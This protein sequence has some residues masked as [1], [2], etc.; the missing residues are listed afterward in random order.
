MA[1]RN[2]NAV[3]AGTGWLYAAEPDG[4]TPEP[5][6]AAA[7]TDPSA[8]PGGTWAGVGYTD[9]GVRLEWDMT[10]EDIRVAEEASP[11]RTLWTEVTYRLALVA[12]QFETAL[13]RLALNG[14]VA[15]SVVGPPE[16]ETFAPPNV[17]ED[18][19]TSLLF[20]F[21]NEYGAGSDLYMAL[22]KNT[23]SASVPFTRAPQKSTIALEFTGQVPAEGPVWSLRQRIDAT[24]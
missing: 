16:E 23:A 19:P 20:R 22:A 9:D 12:A 21:R 14:G 5:A 13:L 24:S 7:P 8:A 4:L 2:P 17:G 11:L 3:L 18:L 6:P 1:N 15:D 10:Y